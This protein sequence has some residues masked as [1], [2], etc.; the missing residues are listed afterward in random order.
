MVTLEYDGT[1][2]LQQKW[3]LVTTD[4]SGQTGITMFDFNQDGKAEI[5]YRDE[6][7]LRVIDGSSAVPVDLVT[8]PCASGT[9]TETAI[10]ADVDNDGSAEICTTCGSDKIGKLKIFESNSTPWA[11]ARKVWNQYNYHVTN[12]NDDL[13]V[14]RYEQNHGIA[15]NGGQALNTSMVQATL[16]A[17]SA[18]PVFPGVSTSTSSVLTSCGGDS[19]TVHYTLSNADSSGFSLPKN[20]VISFY[21]GEPGNGGVLL[22]VDT[23]EQ[24]LAPGNTVNQKFSFLQ[25]PSSFQ[26]YLVTNSA[27]VSGS[28]LDVS[29]Y[30]IP[31]CTYANNIEGPM[32]IEFCDGPVADLNGIN[33]PGRNYTTTFTEDGGAMPLIPAPGNLRDSSNATITSVT[34]EILNLL[35]GSDE[36][37]D[38]VT[39]SS[40]IS[41]SYS[42]A[43]L[44]LSGSHDT[45][46]YNQV[47]KT[48]TYLNT[49]QNPATTQRKVL[50]LFVNGASSVSDSSLV[51]VN[52]IA[53]NDAPV[54][55]TDY[56]I[57]NEDTP[58]VVDVQ[59]NDTDADG[60]VL[61]TTI[62][63]DATNGMAILNN[64]SISYTPATWFVVT[65]MAVN[66]APVVSRVSV[67]GSVNHSV[68]FEASD[69]TD[70]FQDV[71][72][73]A[74][75]KIKITSLPANGTLWVGGNPVMVNDEIQ[76]A[77][78]SSLI[79]IP[80]AN[81]QG[82]ASFGWNGFDGTTY[83][84]NQAEVQITISTQ[85]APTV[86][87]G[88]KSTN[89]ETALRFTATDF[90]NAF[91]DADGDTLQKIKI[92]RLPANG[93]LLLNGN[94]L[95]I[96][97]EIPVADLDQLTFVPNNN[98]FGTTSFD[99][100]G[101]DGT[102]YA[103]SVA[104]MNIAVV[105]VDDDAPVASGKTF[106]LAAGAPL[107]RA[108][109]MDAVTDPEGQGLTFQ[110]TPMA[111]VSH[112][113]LTIYPDGT[114]TYIPTAGY[115]GTDSF[116]YQVCDGGNPQECTT[117]TVTLEIGDQ[118]QDAD[119]DQ[120]GIPDIIEIGNDPAH[121]ADTD[122]DGIPDFK[123]TD[124]D[125]DGIPD[126]EEAGNDPA[127]PTDTDGDGIPDFQ[128]TDSDGDGTPDGE[129]DVITIYKGFSPNGDGK[130]EVWWIEDIEKYPNN[131]VQIFNRWGNKIFDM[132]SYNNQD[133]AWGSQS[134]IGLVVGN[135]G[136]P[137]GTY[138]YIIDLGDNS[139]SRK[140]YVM[141]H[142]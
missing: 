40:G 107:N 120:D 95:K 121:P 103:N 52:I 44:T 49:N 72:G 123:E 15:F 31:Q 30:I 14:P 111:N 54:A 48:L 33:T 20:F 64:D 45:S 131:R 132:K 92:I 138:F 113:S 57:T 34:I 126:S 13:T 122:G 77:D 129:E 8:T 118:N 43:I 53:L 82:L 86:T 140:G 135:A 11:P 114:F 7:N 71:E 76:S 79:F 35:D 94:A 3:S 42:N 39:G 18:A 67:S 22:G 26:L 23:L 104:T 105:P 136:V 87:G 28:S 90:A 119:S 1:T 4:G 66:D 98:F 2:T 102:A 110:T 9:G 56:V 27:S 46:V 32:R 60:D 97:D 141:V 21:N 62:I 89:E 24:G 69:F 75:T 130:N 115:V 116:T 88:N 47:F 133:R 58:I 109:L 128:E 73:S 78:L 12:I 68:Y 139:A 85:Q 83:A 25:Q 96:N 37:L 134:S 74:L 50:V 137:D 84:A 55:A 101:Y 61:T 16:Y 70:Q 51:F 6:F 100:N 80:A 117:G 38:V 41:K 106:T 127:H 142:R 81:Y 124:S 59:D 5:V 93:Q 91:S 29:D 10:V 99:W 125:G 19:I 63:R 36:T 112:G 65:I 17:S 108:S